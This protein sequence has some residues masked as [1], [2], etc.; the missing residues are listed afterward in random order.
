M[1]DSIM[2]GLWLI[3]GVALAVMLVVVVL[4]AIFPRKR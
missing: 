2:P 3:A 1:A 4:A